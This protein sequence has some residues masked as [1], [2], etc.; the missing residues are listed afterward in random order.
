M[1]GGAAD[2]HVSEGGGKMISLDSDGN[3][4]LYFL[5]IDEGK[6]F[7]HPALE[8]GRPYNNGQAFVLVRASSYPR[9]RPLAVF[10][11]V[12][13]TRLVSVFACVDVS[14]G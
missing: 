12:V 4:S 7:Q 13:L 5:A 1:C 3:R 2:H 8:T 10:P 14:T 9:A 11:S 6:D